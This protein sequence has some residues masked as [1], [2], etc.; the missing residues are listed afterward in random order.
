MIKISS[1][2]PF[3][4]L[5]RITQEFH[6]D[7]VVV[8][9][10]SFTFEREFEFEYKDIA[11]IS[12]EDSASTDQI[13]FGFGLLA[14]GLCSV[15]FVHDVLHI[16]S[17]IFQITQAV[18]ISAAIL[19]FTGFIKN[20]YYY[21][22]DKNKKYIT[23]IKM[24]RKN[25]DLTRKAIELIKNKSENAR[26]L[27]PDKP[28]P[29]TKPI[30]EIVKY[31]IPNYFNKSIERLYE[32]E[33]IGYKKNMVSESVYSVKFHLLNGKVFRGKR[34]NDNWDIVVWATL[35]LAS[36]IGVTYTIFDFFPKPIF[37]ITMAVLGILLTIS[38]SL[39]FVK[40]EAVGFYDKNE[41]IA[42]WTWVNNSNREKV[43]EVIKFIQSKIPVEK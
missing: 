11:E 24:T 14:I 9:T 6:E 16:D 30:F 29:E 18:Y 36:I 21:F 33:L 7:K 8:K 31:D 20:K 39:Q 3:S 10:K 4:K 42:Y 35:I 15:F 25:N 40:Y 26:E 13:N 28:F 34:G 43:E 41:N 37:L 22:S 38:F 5:L 17:V 19:L 1:I 23:V 32:N 2:Y 12:C 27:T